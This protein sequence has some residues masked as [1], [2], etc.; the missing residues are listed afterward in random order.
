MTE[1]LALCA[2]FFFA[3]SSVVARVATH[4][5]GMIRGLLISLATSTAILTVLVV[6]MK[7]PQPVGAT[8]LLFFAAAG[9]VGTG[10]GQV[11][12]IRGVRDLG[13]SVAVPIQSSASPVLAALVGWIALAEP[14]SA[15]RI[16]ALVLIL[17][18]VWSC[19]A[20][21]TTPPRGRAVGVLSILVPL[22]AGAAFGIAD[23]LRKFALLNEGEVLTGALVG[24]AAALAGW[25]LVVVL[26]SRA[27]VR[28]Q[29]NSS[30]WWYMLHGVLTGM[31]QVAVLFALRTGDISV[32]SPI[33]ASQAV[34]VVALGVLVLQ[35]FERI[36]L[37]VTFG[38]HLVFAG[39]VL[40]GLS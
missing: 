5:E 1:A 18:G 30:R 38:V 25:M 34:I 36:T 24:S 2:A 37:K 17:A 13:A 19:W 33:V 20:G 9:F 10:L 16:F 8:P 27:R 7:P 15:A 32:V 39:I 12:I 11:L 35:R 40:M 4:A 23:V 31:A 6:A 21:G 29:V 28:D 22:G 14:V 3:A 26:S